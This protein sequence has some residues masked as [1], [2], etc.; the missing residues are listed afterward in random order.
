MCRPFPFLHPPSPPSWRVLADLPFLLASSNFLQ[1]RTQAGDGSPLV[2]RQFTE[3]S[4][5]GLS[6]VMPCCAPVFNLKIKPTASWISPGRKAGLSSSLLR[7]RL[8][9]NY[10]S[11]CLG[12][13]SIFVSVTCSLISH[14]SVPRHT[15]IKTWRF[16]LSRPCI[17]LISFSCLCVTLNVSTLYYFGL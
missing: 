3:T 4:G 7:A 11:T 16:C 17:S 6:L 12:I 9:M 10:C 15:I 1:S 5:C 13:N 2:L 8:L 14:G